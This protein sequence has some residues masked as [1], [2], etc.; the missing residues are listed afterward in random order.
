MI[1]SK[2]FENFERT[3]AMQSLLLTGFASRQIVES[4]ELKAFKK[5]ASFIVT[6]S[7]VELMC[8][9]ADESLSIMEEFF[10][11]ETAI[12]TCLTLLGINANKSMIDDCARAVRKGE[13][14]YSFVRDIISSRKAKK[15]NITIVYTSLREG[16]LGPLGSVRSRVF[17]CAWLTFGITT[18]C[19]YTIAKFLSTVG[20]GVFALCFVREFDLSER[21]THCYKAMSEIME[22]L[23]VGDEV[24]DISL[25]AKITEVLLYIG[26]I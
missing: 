13:A 1:T 4:P 9:D 18:F 2:E 24:S 20:F 11:V 26:G 19:G 6:K 16:Y 12:E 10:L 25:T 3:A 15:N 7:Y 8:Y 22:T 23:L 21:D 5:S 14:F 17:M